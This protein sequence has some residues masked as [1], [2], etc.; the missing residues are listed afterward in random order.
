VSD[1]EARLIASEPTREGFYRWWSTLTNEERRDCWYDLDAMA[2]PEVVSS[3]R[4]K[5]AATEAKLV[6]AERELK[7]LVSAARGVVA[8]DTYPTPDKTRFEATM[9]AIGKLEALLPQEPP[10]CAQ[11]DKEGG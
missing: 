4:A 1:L 2:H 9:G 11:R 6:E 7:A 5:L 3:L 10:A 8:A